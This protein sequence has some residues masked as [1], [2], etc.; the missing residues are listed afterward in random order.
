MEEPAASLKMEAAGSFGKMVNLF[1]TMQILSS[2]GEDY[3][4]YYV[5]WYVILHTLPPLRQRQHVPLKCWEISI[6]LQGVIT[7]QKGVNVYQTIDITFQ[8]INIHRP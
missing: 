6:R 4:D 7:A 2:Q 5:L 1:Q 3:E 8:K